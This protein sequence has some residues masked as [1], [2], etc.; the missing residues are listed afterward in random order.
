MKLKEI[1]NNYREDPWYISWARNKKYICDGIYVDPEAHYPLESYFARY[2]LNKSGEKTLS[3]QVL[4]E[5][6][7]VLNVHIKRFV[8]T[9]IRN[10]FETKWDKIWANLILNYKPQSP[11]N[12]D[13]K[14][15]TTDNLNSSTSSTNNEE[16]VSSSNDKTITNDEESV[17]SIYSFNNGAEVP[18]DKNKTHSENENQSNDT[19]TNRTTKSESYNRQNPKTREY[20]RSGNI[21]N[22][23]ITQLLNEDIEFR[24]IQMWDIMCSDLDTIFTR[25]IYED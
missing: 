13:Y 12:I 21:G 10:K 8:V 20:N 3:T 19:S 7:N 2:Y 24:R 14:E 25:S 23:S 15:Q 11:Y 1:I 16:N 5:T 18:S 4:N 6:E 17:N 22:K 9:E